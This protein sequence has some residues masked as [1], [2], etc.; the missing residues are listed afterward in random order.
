MKNNIVSRIILFSCCIFLIFSCA[1]DDGGYKDSSS[2]GGGDPST[3]KGGSMARF[4]VK[5]DYL[6]IVDDKTLK[7][8]DVSNAPNPQYL[9]MRDQNIGFGIETIFSMDSLLFIGSESAMYIYN[10]S[11]PD[12]PHKLGMATHVTSCDPVVA[13]GNYAYVTLNSKNVRCGNGANELKI[14]DVSNPMSP[15]L[16]KTIQLNNPRG[17]GIDENLLFICVD[18][19]VVAYRISNPIEPEFGYDLHI[20]NTR[21]IDTYDLIPNNGV[22]IITG[23]DG[24]YQFDYTRSSESAGN[25]DK[26]EFL[27]KIDVPKKS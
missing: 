23:E 21:G 24:I 14:Y 13:K 27:S 25:S 2:D 16:K 20:P 10:I 6:Y 19:G 18:K 8:V 3:G 11:R 1:K 15:S 22:L 4:T 7:V 12:Y 26:F 9:Y 5:G 17:L